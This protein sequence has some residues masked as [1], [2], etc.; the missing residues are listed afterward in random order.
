MRFPIKLLFTL[1]FFV[2][3]SRVLVHAQCPVADPL[4][5]DTCISRSGPVELR[6]SGSTGF[7]NWYDS[8]VGDRII[9]S[10]DTYL[11]PQI[12]ADRTF[13]ISAIETNTSLNLDGDSS[14]IALDRSYNAVEAIPQLT[15]EAWVNTDI[16]GTGEF[17]NWSIIDYDRSEYFNLFVR[18]DNGEVGFSTSANTGGTVDF[19]SGVSV[20]DGRWHHVAAVYDGTDKIIYVDG[21]Q[22]ATQGNPHGGLGLGRGTLRYGFIGDGSEADAFNGARNRRYYTGLVD[23]V[24][25]WSDVRTATEIM[26]YKDSCLTGS[27]ADLESYYD[28]N[29]NGGAVVNDLTGNGGDGTIYNL[30]VTSAWLAG[31]LV[32]C[33][34]ESDLVPL[35]I[36][37]E[38]NLEDTILTACVPGVQL[39]AGP[40]ASSYSWSTGETSQT[41]SVTENGFYEVVKTGGA[42]PGTA[43]I[44]VEGFTHAESALQFD[45]SNDFAAIDDMRYEQSNLEELTVETWLRTSVAGDQII[46]SFD[47]SEYWRLEI[48]GDG[49]GAGQIGF[50]V[51]TSSGIVDFGSDARI[52][53]GEWH[54]VACVFDHGSMEIYI[55]G[56]LDSDTT[57]GVTFGSGRVRY[58][59]L[60]IGSEAT[61]FNG[62]TGPNSRFDGQLDEFRIWHRALSPLEIRGNMARHISG[63]SNGL[64]VSYKFDDISANTIFDHSTRSESNAVMYN[65]GGGA[66][67][68]STAPIGDESA[69]LYPGSW[70]GESLQLRYC[71]G[72]SLTV[73][74][75][76]GS[77]TGVHIYSV[78]RV[79]DDVSGILGLGTNDRYFGVHKIGDASASY[80]ATY[81]YTGGEANGHEMGVESE[82]LLA[83][84]S[85]SDRSDSPWVDTG[86]AQDEIANTLT[87]T[88]SS[89]EFILGSTGSPL[90]IELLSFQAQA[91]QEKVQLRWVTTAEIN[92]DFFTIERSKDGQQWEDIFI[93]PGAGNS[94]QT[95]RYTEVD[96]QP[97]AGLAYYRLKQTDFNGEFSHSAPV[98]VYFGE[99]DAAEIWL[100]PNPVEQGGRIQIRHPIIGDTKFTIS[101]RDVSGKVWL[102][103]SQASQDGTESMH[104]SID[105]SIPTGMYM[106]TLSTAE[107]VYHQRLIVN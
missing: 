59:F 75:M 99:G 10:G 1:L 81:D 6:A 44:A 53:D 72:E 21:V 43:R 79:P 36:S 38:G 93:I 82:S 14:Y 92:N 71:S 106:L 97:L 22:V 24:R 61:V 91:E 28:F 13:Y 84:F 83:L 94:S 85:R 69:F 76:S 101:L 42:C 74:N 68:L 86:A 39:D 65:F 57:G 58:G 62:A 70:T 104:L 66:E 9:A 90:P 103:Q 7:Y 5:S 25:L 32:T 47:R 4:T 27:E 56:I 17:S 15:V 52:D 8:P 77:P 88:A 45:G 11:T 18:G 51:M 95:L 96:E 50:D 87:T 49:A 37:I 41:I 89:T 26:D 35:E 19:Y 78:G 54:H 100:F 102:E 2:I 29:E 3:L 67:V 30:D 12:S 55:D 107:E 64:E 40:S 80:S 23:E 48:N 33:D 46:A 98:A 34:C 105:P 20:N 63:N 60:G 16:G 73:S 31:A